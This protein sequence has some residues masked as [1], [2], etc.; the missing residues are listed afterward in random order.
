M[1]GHVKMGLLIGGAIIAATAIWIYFSP[2]QTCVRAY[3]ASGIPQGGAEISCAH[4]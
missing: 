2:F 1:S 3:A 4:R